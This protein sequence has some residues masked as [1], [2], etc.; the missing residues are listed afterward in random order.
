MQRL[1]QLFQLVNGNW[2]IFIFTIIL[3]IFHRATY[4]YVPLFS[5][6]VIQKLEYMNS[7][8]SPDKVVNLPKFIIDIVEKNSEVINAVITIIVLM[9]IWQLIR[10]IVLYF[11]AI[12]KG[13]F[14]EN[15]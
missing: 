14:S 4:S 12:I 6:Y 11:E 15:V 5:E 3:T 13:R 2:L 1:K 7:D 8:E 9:L 10:Y